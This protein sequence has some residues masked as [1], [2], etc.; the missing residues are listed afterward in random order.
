MSSLSSSA[1]VIEQVLLYTLR[2]ATQKEV[3]Y[4]V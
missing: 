4:A 1:Q 2:W 3:T